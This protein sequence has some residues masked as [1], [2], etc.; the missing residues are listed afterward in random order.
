MTY[1]SRKNLVATISPTPYANPLLLDLASPEPH[2]FFLSVALSGVALVGRG[3]TGHGYVYS[4]LSGGDSNGDPAPGLTLDPLTGAIIGTPTEQGT[5]SFV[6]QV[7]DSGSNTFQ[8]GFTIKVEADLFATVYIP[9]P[10]EDGIAYRFEFFVYDGA[11]TRITS[12]FTLADG[13]LPDGLSI[14]SAGVI[15]GTPTSLAIGTTYG[16][17]NVDDGTS[18]LDITIAIVV[19]AALSATFTESRDPPEGWGGGAGTWLPSVIRGI[20]TDFNITIA[21][22]VPPYSVSLS[23]I[24]AWP[25]GTNLINGSVVRIKTLDASDALNPNL[26]AVI[27]TDSLGATVTVQRAYFLI[28]SPNGRVTHQLNG[29][30]VAGGDGPVIFNL[31]EGSGVTITPSNTGEKISY[32]IAASSAAAQAKIQFEYNTTALGTSGTVDTYDVESAWANFARASNTVTLTIPT[33]S[34][35][36][37]GLTFT[38]ATGSLTLGGTLAIAYGGTGQT[39][40]TLAFTALSPQ[41]TKGDL[42]A[43]DG[44]N[45]VR[46]AVGSN[47]L[48]LVADSAASAGVSYKALPVAGG[49]TGATTAASARGN[50]SAAPNSPSYVTLATNAELTSERVLTGVGNISITDNGAGNTV[51]IS[52]SGYPDVVNLIGGTGEDGNVDLDGSNTYSFFNKVGSVYT[53]NRNVAIARLRISSGV[54]FIGNAGKISIQQWVC[55]S[56]FYGTILLDGNNGGNASGTTA[57][58]LGSARVITGNYF[59]AASNGSAGSAGV[60]GN[61]ASTS[62]GGGSGQSWGGAGSKGGKGG[63][64]GTGLGAS[65]GAAGSAS[66]YAALSGPF[67]PIWTNANAGV[68]AAGAGGSGGTGGGGDGTNAGGGAGG[69]GAGG[70]GID[71]NVGEIVTDASTPTMVSCNGGNGG[72]GANG[73]GVGNTGGGAGGGAGGGGSARLKVGK[74]TG[75]SVTSFMTANGGTGGNGGTGHGTGQNGAGAD[76]GSNGRLFLWNAMAGTWSV[77]AS[78]SAGSA[79][80]GATGGAGATAAVNL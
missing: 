16:T 28:D 14:S 60:T 57:G 21:D 1:P 12:G 70:A 40:A 15:S 30:T 11:G 61:S 79:A 65:S 80:S 3:G 13:A 53:Q 9:T 24:D 29:S 67:E 43:D 39:T 34:G 2:R 49:G 5:F 45:P 4:I 19:Y 56:G 18:S 78:V 23:T 37:T 47:D 6:A 25:T 52:V 59:A 7:E 20:S 26:S 58:A 50:L 38:A 44:T 35:G 77:I 69:G 22:G 54:T 71:L 72:A 64:G 33:P 51:V 36:T 32:E 66:G 31:V 68:Y 55:T 73:A 46:V 10:G 76:G 8:H 27:V 75:P 42:I 62:A 41:T 17:V 74:V 63:N 48:P